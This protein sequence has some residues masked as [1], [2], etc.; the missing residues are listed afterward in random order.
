[1]DG[2]GKETERGRGERKRNEANWEEKGGKGWQYRSRE[3][4]EKP[5]RERAERGN[6]RGMQKQIR[7]QISA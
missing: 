6:E 2:K 1:M 7:F 4:K 5:D 3:K